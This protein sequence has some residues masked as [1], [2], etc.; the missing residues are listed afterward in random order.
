MSSKTIPPEFKH[1]V[2]EATKALIKYQLPGGFKLHRWKEPGSFVELQKIESSPDIP[3]KSI[4]VK[5]RWFLHINWTFRRVPEEAEWIL[6][7]SSIG[8]SV[9][10]V[11]FAKNGIMKCLV[12]YDY[13][14]DH[15]GPALGPIGPHLNILQPDPL[16][17][18]LHFPVLSDDRKSWSVEEVLDALLSDQFKSELQDCMDS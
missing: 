13:D 15:P 10:D 17:D 4:P 14:C 1:I 16:K 12:R 5:G 2:R 18:S 9:T 6:W 11:S 8:L 7:Q 3:V